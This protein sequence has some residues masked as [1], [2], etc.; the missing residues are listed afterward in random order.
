VTARRDRPGP[1]GVPAR[2][3]T[4]TGALGAT[5]TSA[6]L[7]TAHQARRAVREP[8][9][10]V[11][12]FHGLTENAGCWD[13]VLPL[14]PDD[15]DAWVFGLPWDGA[16]GQ[17]WALERDTDVWVERALAL[18]PAEPT[19]LVAHSFG[20]NVLLDY[21]DRGPL[22]DRLK[23]V[24]LAPFF[25]PTRRHFDWTLISYYLNDFHLFLAGGIAARR[26]R[27][28]PDPELLIG[29]SQKVRDRIGAYGWL[30]FFELFSRTP[31]LDLEALTVPVVVVGGEQDRA[32]FPAD[33]RALAAALPDAR[34]EI[35][36]G[37]GHHLMLEAPERVAELIR[38]LKEGRC[39][40]A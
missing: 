14:L 9:T 32:S 19:L 40:A 36:P 7:V 39:A 5:T 15:V 8:V 37:C 6:A 25:R 1:P 28:P 22:P 30:R 34:V 18:L 31:L 17:D 38:E 11:A 35:L 29:M 12:F 13:R 27:R 26:R 10:R 4:R 33:C 21:L 23:L 24:L 2:A 20:A 16:H 3:A